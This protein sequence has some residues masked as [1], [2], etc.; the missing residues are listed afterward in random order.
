[1]SSWARAL[2]PTAALAAALAGIILMRG[3]EDHLQQ[4]VSVEEL[5]VSDLEGET[6][7]ATLGPDTSGPAITFA[8]E[9]F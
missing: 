1:M 6:I 4:M 2:L 8:S 3:P 7:P 5:L 9:I